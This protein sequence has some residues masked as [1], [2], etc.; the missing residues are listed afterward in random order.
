M[1]YSTKVQR[2]NRK[3][4][5][6]WYVNFPAAV[7]QAIE[8]TPGEVVEWIIDDHQNLVLR[9]NDQAV[10]ALKKKLPKRKKI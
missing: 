10:A 3:S 1:G 2:I 9:R 7:A 4:S 5:E 6:Q 8:F